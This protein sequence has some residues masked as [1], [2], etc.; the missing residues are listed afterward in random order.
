MKIEVGKFYKTRDGN[1]VR[2]YAMDGAG[3]FPIHGAVLSAG[4]WVFCSWSANGLH[5]NE[6][7]D[8][9]PR[10]LVSEWANFGPMPERLIVFQRPLDIPLN[11]TFP[12]YVIA[13]TLDQ[14]MHFAKVYSDYLP[15]AYRIEP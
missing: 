9:M 13:Y 6:E 14:Q 1:K 7:G 8:S 11:Y 4:V 3:A 5:T 2:I 15:I 12:E 10:D